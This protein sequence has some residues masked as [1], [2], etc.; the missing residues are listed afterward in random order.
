[1][2][3]MQ[4]RARS[5]SKPIGSNGPSYQRTISRR[6]SCAGSEDRLQEVH[7]PVRA[8]DVLRR[9]A[10]GPVHE[11]RI[12]PVRGAVANFLDDHVVAPVVAVVVGVD[13]PIHAP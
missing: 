1:M 10:S 2:F 3:S 8:A 7:E 11:G 13:E 5:S 6:C 4:K 9:T 12:L